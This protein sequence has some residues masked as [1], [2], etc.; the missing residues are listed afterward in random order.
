MFVIVLGNKPKIL[1]HLYYTLYNIYNLKLLEQEK[2][3]SL[4]PKIRTKPWV[5]GRSISPQNPIKIIIKYLKNLHVYRLIG[6]L[7]DFQS[8]FLGSN[9][10]KH[11][12]GRKHI[13]LGS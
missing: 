8:P 11:K 9:P 6:K 7:S 12:G 2:N 3:N 13:C 5:L 4:N 1:D 10:S